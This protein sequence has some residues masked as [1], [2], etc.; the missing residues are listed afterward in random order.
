MEEEK[1]PVAEPT[2]EVT[3]EG[4]NPSNMIDRA[5]TA[6][7]TITNKMA[8]LDK[9]IEYYEKLRSEQILSGKSEAGQEPMNRDETPKEYKDRVMR[10]EL[11]D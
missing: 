3:E 10:G 6:A 2:E 4:D 9:K 5:E 11:N 1:K 7:T 8:E